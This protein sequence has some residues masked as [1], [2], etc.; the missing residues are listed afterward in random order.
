MDNK[1]RIILNKFYFNSPVVL[2]FMFLSF[3]I[4]ILDKFTLGA[5][6][7]LCF[8]V[9]RSSLLN[10]LTYVRLIGHVLGHADYTHY[11]NNMMTFLLVGPMLEEKYGSKIMVESILITAVITGVVQM[12]LFPHG[13]LLGA[14]GVVFMMIV[15]SSVTSVKSGTIPITLIMV[16]VLY[17]GQQIIQGVFSADNVS[18]LTHILGGVLGAIF[19]LVLQKKN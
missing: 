14:S 1:K 2:G 4:L 10:P 13:A 9:Y 15:M 5:A 3:I 7:R 16:V 18:Q 6:N 11:I 19:G 17:L 8:M 12:L